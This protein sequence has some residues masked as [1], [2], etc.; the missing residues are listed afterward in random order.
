MVPHWH[1]VCQPQWAVYVTPSN[2]NCNAKSPFAQKQTSN[3][4]PKLQTVVIQCQIRWIHQ[5]S[6]RKDGK[7]R[8]INASLFHDQIGPLESFHIHIRVYKSGTEL[9]YLG[10]VFHYISIS[11][12]VQYIIDQSWLWKHKFKIGFSLQIPYYQNHCSCYS[13]DA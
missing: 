7:W 1:T 6:L 13:Q 2:F 9:F 3:G 4:T 8:R 5:I 10:S 12:Y 11:S